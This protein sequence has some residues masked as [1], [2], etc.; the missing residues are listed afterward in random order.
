M[1]EMLQKRLA[2]MNINLRIFTIRQVL[3]MFCRRMAFS[4]ASLYILAVGGDETQIGIVNSLSPLAGLLMFPISGQLTD[5]T[6]RVKL[7]TLA[8]YLSSVTMLLYVFAQSWEWIA[9]GALLQGFMVFQFPPSSAILADS[10]TPRNRG[11]GIATMNTLANAL[12]IFSPYLAGIILEFYGI[13]FGMRVIYALWIIS[14]TMTATLV[15]KYLNETTI[16]PQAK[17]QLNL[18]GILKDAYSEIPQLIRDLPR[19]VKALGI[20]MGM[21]FIANGLS[22]PFWVVYVIEDINLSSIEWGL[23]LLFE[24]ILRTL[25][26]IPGGIIADRYSRTKTLCVAILI[27]LFSLPSLIFATTFLHVLLIRLGIGLA[28]AL[29]TPSSAALMADFIPREVRGRVMAAI[30][31]GSTLIGAT[32]GGTG[33]PGMGYLFTVPVMTAS[34]LGGLLYSINPTYPW[35]CVFGTIL[36]QL[37]CIIVFIR[38]SDKAEL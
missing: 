5:H 38:D 1:I 28:G 24:T 35:L 14:R 36:V 11:V 2:F 27:S 34:V 3:L 25:L 26:T 9:L 16:V 22:S 6:G 17:A 23:I 7:I 10:L 20:L 4:Y 18:L 21:S 19:S 32:G 29:F 15:L 31:R 30:G 37:V 8:G 12:A 13:N 33:G